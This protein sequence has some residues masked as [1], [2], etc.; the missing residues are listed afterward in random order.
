MTK[1]PNAIGDNT[2][3]GQIQPHIKPTQPKPTSLSLPTGQNPNPEPI[4]VTD[5][6]TLSSPTS[7]LR[8]GMEYETRHA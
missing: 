5:G 4:E 7:D 3:K 2:S 6:V 1:I 8:V